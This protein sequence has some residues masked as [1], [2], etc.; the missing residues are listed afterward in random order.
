[1]NVTKV[2]A[3]G[4]TLFEM[5]VVI[6]ITGLMAAVLMQGL[7]LVL[8]TR[9]SVTNTIS[10]LQ[11]VV[12]AQNI[13]VDPLRGVVPDYTNNPNT[14]QGQPRAISGQTL[15][16]LLSPGGAPTPFKMTMEYDGGSNQTVLTYE[17]P[18]RPKTELARWPGNQQSFK[19]RDVTGTWQP[20][21]P[22]QAS[23]SQTPWLIWI[24]TGAIAA[25]LIAAVS[26]PHDRVTRL[27]DSPFASAIS[28][29]R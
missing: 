18:G 6:V 9:L 28:P 29:R 23:T 15:R 11:T 8:R 7:G 19:Y 4:F 16:P 10:D 24:D 13:P 12:I 22:P 3:R 5:I 25:P 17:E 26:G 2:T 14:F 21:W 27:E 20:S 1:M